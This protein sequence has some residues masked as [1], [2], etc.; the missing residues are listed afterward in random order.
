MVLVTVKLDQHR[1]PCAVYSPPVFYVMIVW[2]LWLAQWLTGHAKK[3]DAL[4]KRIID[5]LLEIGILLIAFAPLDVAVNPSTAGPQAAKR[6]LIYGVIL[7]V[8]GLLLE[9]RFPHDR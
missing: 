2:R 7:F 4:A 9:W 8:V 3:L 1:S 5:G 6:F